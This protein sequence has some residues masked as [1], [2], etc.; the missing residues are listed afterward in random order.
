LGQ[1]APFKLKEIWGIRVR[2]PLSGRIRDLALLD[3]ATDSKLPACDRVKL[4]VRD[5]F[6]G[7]RIGARAIVMQQKT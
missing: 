3:L 2:L 4:R 7:D 1:K 6:H 5:V